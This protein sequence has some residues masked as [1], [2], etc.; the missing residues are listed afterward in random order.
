M[1]TNGHGATTSAQEPVRSHLGR[2]AMDLAGYALVAAVVVILATTVS[3]LL[4]RCFGWRADSVLSG[5]MEPGIRT[6]S[7]VLTK[8]AEAREIKTGD[9]IVFQHTVGV[10]QPERILIA[11]RVVDTRDGTSFRTKGDANENPDPFLVPADDIVGTVYCDIPYL[12]RLAELAGTPC[13]ISVLGCCAGMLVVAEVVRIR[14]QSPV[15]EEE[16]C[17]AE[18][19][20]GDGPT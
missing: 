18:P 20:S 1:C 11:H 4:L 10:E 9:V 16:D 6:G 19:E 14:R 3:V 2:H 5:S 7:L 8:S 13:G 15:G 12:G 17:E